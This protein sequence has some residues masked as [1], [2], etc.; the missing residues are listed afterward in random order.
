MKNRLK[1]GFRIHGGDTEAF[2]DNNEVAAVLND[3]GLLLELKGENPF[4]ARA[5]YNGART[6]SVL[7]DDISVLVKNDTL[8]DVK[9]IGDALNKKIKELVTTGHLKYYE[10]LKAQF[11]QSIFELLKIPGLGPKKVSALYLKL[12]IS[13]L[14]EL[15][16]A[17]NENRLLDLPG[18]GKK[19]QDKILS[20]IPNVKEY[21]TKFLYPDALAVG[22]SIVKYIKENAPVKRI[23]IAGSLRRCVETVK[24]I[25]IIASSDLSDDV[26][27]VFVGHPLVKTVTGRGST[28]SSITTSLG[29]NVDLRVVEDDLYVYALAHFTGSKEH[30]TALRSM[31]KDMGLK[32]NEY[33]IFRE[34]ELLKCKDENDFYDTLGL[35]YIPPELRENMGEIEASAAGTLPNLITKDDIKGLLHIHT[36][37]SDGS[38]TVYEMAE[39]VR[40]RGYQ[41][42]GISDHSKSAFYANGLKD[43]D[44][45][46]QWEEIDELNKKY[47][48]FHIYKGIETDIHPD[49][50]I[51]YDE[52]ILKR[53]DFVIASIHTNFHMSHDDMT[54]RI[55]KAVEN[56]Y[57]TMLGHPTGRLLLSREPIDFDIKK[58]IECCAENGVVIEINAHPY[59]L[60]L[61]YQYV[62]IA[63]E[64]YKGVKFSINPDA[65]SI[66]GLD[67]MKYGI[68]AARKG[69]LEHDDI[70]CL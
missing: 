31:A 63:K 66:E 70:Y 4:K 5:Y 41:Y 48:D 7:A 27:D 60:D 11:P 53:F 46:R 10:D 16:Y 59:R 21:M 49:G 57:V 1:D 26:M 22:E 56:P 38:N 43:E 35:S 37:Y 51:D 33:G 64:L 32:I 67:V 2:M 45:F 34:D 39:E 62:K 8:G 12:G 15:E 40:K 20:E 18:F 55:I 17:C 14:G 47:T 58:V 13:T 68:N 42:I 29:I 52:N 61:G 65:H 6:I 50:S 19:T 44:V 28:K 24:D 9:G 54:D 25:D 3:I 69:W 30:N 36:K 23:S